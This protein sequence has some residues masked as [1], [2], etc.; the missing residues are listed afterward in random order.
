MT[1][2]ANKVI[3]FEVIGQVPYLELLSNKAINTLCQ[4]SLNY[5]FNVW[6][7]EETSLTWLM[8]GELRQRLGAFPLIASC[9]LTAT[10]YTHIHKCVLK[11]YR[12]IYGDTINQF[13]CLDALYSVD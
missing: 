9:S 8:F 4:K 5:C 13:L 3:A 6:V 7:I 2:Q 10:S 11:H 12:V 1:T